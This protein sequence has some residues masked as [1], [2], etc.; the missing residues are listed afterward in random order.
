MPVWRGMYSM[1][2]EQGGVGRDCC[3]VDD[4]ESLKQCLHSRVQPLRQQAGS[5]RCCYLALCLH[6]SM[7]RQKGNGPS[8]SDQGG[9][10]MPIAP[11]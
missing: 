4:R 9:Y 7:H 10:K 5:R 1:K 2:K 3:C 8:H 11:E 6:R